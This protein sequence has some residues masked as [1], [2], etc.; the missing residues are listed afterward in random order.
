M[1][2]DDQPDRTDTGTDTPAASP[3]APAAPVVTRRTR[4]AP[5]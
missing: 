3:E 5:A 2:D 4:K 1:L